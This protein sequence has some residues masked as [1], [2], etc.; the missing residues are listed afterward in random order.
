MYST[1]A[2]P[3]GLDLEQIWGLWFGGDST[4]HHPN[5]RRG[6]GDRWTATDKT[7]G[8]SLPDF[9]IL[10]HYSFGLKFGFSS[11]CC[12]SALSLSLS[13]FLS[14][15]LLSIP[16]ATDRPWLM[17]GDAA[18]RRSSSS[19][20]S[21][22]KQPATLRGGTDRPTDHVNRPNPIALLPITP[23]SIARCCCN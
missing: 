8:E 13:F 17:E 16:P 2:Q 22:N 6:F 5:Q 12:L 21:S 4:N 23:P 3:S 18:S 11:R 20:S 19:S 7:V 10:Y 9:T 14:F 15:L 1:Q